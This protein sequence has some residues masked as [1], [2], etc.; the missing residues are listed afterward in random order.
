MKKEV[1]EL[2]IQY[3][4]GRHGHSAI[5]PDM[6]RDLIP[7]TGYTGKGLYFA[8]KRLERGGL[9]EITRSPYGRGRPLIVSLVGPADAEPAGERDE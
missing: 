4:L 6:V 1:E 8:A 2:F 9:L 3:L 7:V 5:L